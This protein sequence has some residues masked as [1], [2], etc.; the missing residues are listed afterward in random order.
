MTPLRQRMIEELELRNLSPKT[1][2]LYVQNIARFAKHFGKSP[3]LLGPEAV[4][5]YLLYLVQERKVAWGTY[6]QVL[7]SLR[8]LYRHVIK[9]G[10]I[11]HDIRAPRRERRLPEVLSLE[12]VRRFFAAVRSF[13]YRTV[14]MTAYSAGLRISETLNLKVSDIDS[15]RMVI[16]V[17]QGKGK[18]D[19][20]TVL[21]PVLLKMLRHY[22]WA[23]RPVD[24]LFP[25]ASRVKPISV[26]QVQRVCRDARDEAE[27]DKAVTP[28]MLRHSFATHLLEA[29]TELRVIQAL[30]GHTSPQTTARYM[31]V[32]TKLISETQSP[33]DFLHEQDDSSSEE[34]DG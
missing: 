19:R 6:N 7:A 9:R 33:L 1:I 2:Q 34:A 5:T 8:F 4:R 24:W 20:Y 13:K 3:Q 21:S 23:A 29:G 27:L 26:G 32:S 17:V 16:R 18:R 25:G 10:E 11:V 14:L 15:E 30:L 28:H 12:E 31:H 22:W